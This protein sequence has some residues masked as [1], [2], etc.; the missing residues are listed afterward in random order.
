[1]SSKIEVTLEQFL[2][3][4]PYFEGKVNEA[5]LQGAYS[6]AQS[7]ISVYEGEIVLPLEL[8]T[9]G[10]YLATAHSLY[11][12][13]NPELLSGGGKIASAREGSVS[14]SY[15]QPQYKNW[16]EYQLSLS[17]YGI[18]LMAILAQV[19]PPMPRKPTNEYPYYQGVYGYAQNKIIGR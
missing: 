3:F 6:G 18:E 1:M 5:Q 14:V 9:R 7:Y 8:Q 10:V 13:L 11:M 19:Q 4:F 16:L 12:S 15:T 2:T 17:P